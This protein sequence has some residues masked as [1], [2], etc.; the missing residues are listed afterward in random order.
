MSPSRTHCHEDVV[1]I[2]VFLRRGETAQ[3]VKLHMHENLSFDLSHPHKKLNAVV[4]STSALRDKNRGIPGTCWV[5]NLPESVS[6]KPQE[7]TLSQKPKCRMTED[8]T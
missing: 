5:V 6:P 8:N 2:K 7:E 4:S 1:F 3:S